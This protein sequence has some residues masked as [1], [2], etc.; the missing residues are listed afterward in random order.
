M[1]KVLIVDDVPANLKII[2]E[3]LRDEFDVYV[4]TSGETALSVAYSLLPDVILM[5]I[6][7]PGMDGIT[8]CRW[9]QNHPDTAEIPVIF[10][11]AKQHTED[12]VK[13]FEA[14]GVDYITKPF[15]PSELYARLTTHLEVK[16]SREELRKNAERLRELNDELERTNSQLEEAIERLHVAAMTDHLT[17][18]ANRRF[19]VDKIHEE[20][21]RN[22]RTGRTCS[23]VIA[24]I[25]NF[26]K[27]NDTYGHECGDYVLKTVAQ[28]LRAG[29]RAGDF[30][31]RW[32]G[33]EFFLLLP[34]T[35][36]EGAIH[37]SEKLRERIEQKQ[38]IYFGHSIHI[39][40]TFGIALYD[41]SGNMDTSIRLA[42]QALYE[43]KDRGKNCVVVL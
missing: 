29:L 23:F 10:I 24:D 21:V 36:R 16:R 20:I 38:F 12:I 28:V 13:G 5:D 33:E 39:T 3:L 18:V 42:D 19:M 6:I 22:K 2:G 34:E 8:A 25:D 43:G 37:V 40:M 7:M 14:G 35:E 1:P 31:A 9:L 11:T 32:G 26:K 15:H 17:G 4:A 30:V 41:A 27:I